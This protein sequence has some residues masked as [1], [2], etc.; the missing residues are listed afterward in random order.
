VI[1]TDS[2][3]PSMLRMV[4]M[5]RLMRLLKLARILRASRIFSRWENSISMP[6]ASRTLIGWVIAISITLHWFACG[7]G[8]L[9]QMHG[10]LRDDVINDLEAVVGARMQHDPFCSGCNRTDAVLDAKYCGD[11]TP[12]LT[13]CEIEELAYLNKGSR[14]LPPWMHAYE[15]RQ[16]TKSEHW[17]CRYSDQGMALDPREHLKVFVA[18]LHVAMLQMGGGVG[19]IVPENT[20]EF[21]VFFMC[22]LLGSVLWAIVVGTICGLIATGDPHDI[23]YRQTMDSLNY[24]LTDLNI[25]HETRIKTREYLRQARYLSKH[26]AYIEL[27]DNFSHDIRNDL[28]LRM[29]S[30][31]LNAVWYLAD[32]GKECPEFIIDLALKLDRTCWA[33]KEKISAVQLNIIMRG[34]VAKAGNI[35]TEGSYWGEDIII[36][37]PVLRDS[38][39]VST[40]SYVEVCSLSRDDVE[41]S[42]V[43][44]PD[45]NDSIRKAAVLLATNRASKV[46]AEYYRL[47]A[48]DKLTVAYNVFGDKRITADLLNSKDPVRILQTLTGMHGREVSHT[49][50]IVEAPESRYGSLRDDETGGV[51]DDAPVSMLVNL[52]RMVQEEQEERRSLTERHIEEL[53]N[54]TERHNEELRNAI[55]QKEPDEWRQMAAQ[56]RLMAAQ[57]EAMQADLQAIKKL[58]LEQP[59]HPPRPL[60]SSMI[61]PGLTPLMTTPGPLTPLTP[62]RDPGVVL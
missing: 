18:A 9:A 37:V 34:V 57:Q 27:V 16:I 51:E 39:G 52:T 55:P 46:I 25:P 6:N 62:S 15:M 17:I 44:F 48:A 29:S 8:L 56:Q 43:Q 31:T 35:M 12:C 23:N 4:R 2:V 13:P 41:E 28:V 1:D 53:R 26:Q 40:L 59:R 47:H 30:A 45:A 19:S 21:M 58:L 36:T 42:L 61:T 54:L 33:P 49:G 14:T 60:A 22:T 10:S 7:L 38:R 32:C 20:S 11:M 50:E 24:F 3:N 5:V